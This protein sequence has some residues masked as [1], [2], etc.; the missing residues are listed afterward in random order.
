[1]FGPVT[2]IYSVLQLEL[3]L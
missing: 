2:G 1:M 3:V